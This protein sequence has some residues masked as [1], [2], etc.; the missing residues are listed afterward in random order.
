MDGL[1]HAGFINAMAFKVLYIS[2][3]GEVLQTIVLAKKE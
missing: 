3:K 2:S 1:K